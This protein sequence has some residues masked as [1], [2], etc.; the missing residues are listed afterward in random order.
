[1]LQPLLTFAA[2]KAIWIRLHQ[3]ICCATAGL[4]LQ[5]LSTSKSE[6]LRQNLVTMQGGLMQKPIMRTMLRRRRD[7][8]TAACKSCW[9]HLDWCDIKCK[10]PPHGK[11]NS[12][13]V[14]RKFFTCAAEPTGELLRRTSGYA[15]S[16]SM[17][18]GF[19]NTLH[20]ERNLLNDM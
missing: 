2:S 4:A 8:I 15:C 5:V 17:Q 11:R 18:H 16:N 19:V 10:L 7:D 1:M 9:P 14:F 20:S 6:P 12:I 13:F 3:P